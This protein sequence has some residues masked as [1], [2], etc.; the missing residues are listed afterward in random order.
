M[1]HWCGVH[2]VCS[3]GCP[4]PAR[5][6][7]AVAA[8]LVTATL[9][10]PFART[11]L[12]GGLGAVWRL[13]DADAGL[14][15]DDLLTN[16]YRSF[17]LRQES[18]IYDRLAQTVAGDQLTEIYLQS[19]RSPELENRGGARGRVDDVEILEVHGVLGGESGGLSV[20][21]TWKVS[22]S[23]SHF[24]HTHYRQNRNRAEIILAPVEGIWKIVGITIID[25]QRVL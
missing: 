16:V 25:E 11:P 9:L 13:S 21:A 18:A 20:D 7:P 17:D 8:A 2:R 12:A 15:L 1:G 23:V 24:G 22:G 6:R 19:R 3:N 14:V 5:T 4:S 10:Y